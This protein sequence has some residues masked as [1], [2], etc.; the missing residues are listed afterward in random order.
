MEDDQASLPPADWQARLKK[1]LGCSLHIRHVDAG[2]CNGC[3]FEMMA[4]C[5]PVYDVQ[6][7][8]IEFVASPRHADMLL[9]TGGVTRHLAEALKKTYQ[10]AAA[11]KLV[12]AVGSCA[13]SGGIAGQSY[14][15]AGG[16]DKIV[17]VDV[18]IPGCPPRPAALL[19]GILLALNR[20]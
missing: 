14:A 5:N 13:C 16:V 17:P 7:F 2:S 10:A 19:E 1:L 4:L 11:P 8:G 12:V 18:Y 9:V 6:R 15:N 20:V 3:D